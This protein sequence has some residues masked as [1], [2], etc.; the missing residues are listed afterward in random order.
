MADL[1]RTFI[2]HGL[3]NELRIDAAEGS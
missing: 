3:A 2:L 1:S